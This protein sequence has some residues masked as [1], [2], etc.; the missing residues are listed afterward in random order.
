MNKIKFAILGLSIF[1]GSVA[2]AQEEK[3]QLTKKERME[4]RMAEE[5]K[6]L[7]LSEDQKIQFFEL[8]KSSFEE[9][10]KIKNNESLDQESKKTAMKALSVQHKERLAEILTED[11]LQKLQAMKEERRE[12]YKENRPGKN[13]RGKKKGMNKE[14]KKENRVP[15]EK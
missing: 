14:M 8:R 9:R 13:H 12:N 2:F 7:G 6:E 3:T 4:Q 15:A 10:Q 11:Q 5:A 1:I